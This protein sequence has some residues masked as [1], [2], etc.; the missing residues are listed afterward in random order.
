ML[1]LKMVCLCENNSELQNCTEFCAFVNKILKANK[2]EGQHCV[3]HISEPADHGALG[4]DRYCLV[5]ICTNKPPSQWIFTM[6]GVGPAVDASFKIVR[7]DA[8]TRL[9]SIRPLHLVLNEAFVRSA[10]QLGSRDLSASQWS[11]LIPTAS[12]A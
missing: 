2:L 6:A 4:A 12:V 9:P 5:G 10:G 3:L 11:T 7:S 1:S 8:N